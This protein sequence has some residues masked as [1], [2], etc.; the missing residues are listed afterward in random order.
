LYCAV[1]ENIHTP[2]TEG[3][4]ISWGVGGSLRPKNLI[5]ISRGVGGSCKKSLP[6]GRY[7]YFL[8][9]HIVPADTASQFLRNMETSDKNRFLLYLSFVCFS[10]N[11]I[12]DVTNRY[13]SSWMSKTRK[14]RIDSDWW[15]DTLQPYKSRNKV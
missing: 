4:G 8:E 11:A 15:D 2:P 9:L 7:G 1:P 5:E 6:W 14:L 13:A 3:I 12:K 10:E